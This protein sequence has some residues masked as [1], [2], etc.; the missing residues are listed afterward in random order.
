VRPGEHSI[1]VGDV[2][3]GNAIRAQ[4]LE[5]RDSI[6]VLLPGPTLVWVFLVRK[7]TKDLLETVQDTGTGV[8]FID[9]CRVHVPLSD[10]RRWPPNVA[11]VHARACSVAGCVKSCSALQLN[12]Q[13]GVLTSGVG[14]VI[15][16][17]GRGYKPKALGTENRPVG[18]ARPS[19]GD[20]G[21]A[22]RFY[23]EFRSVDDFLKW[24]QTL[25][26]LP[27]VL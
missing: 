19:Y 16:I 27:T 22:S 21:G 10:E 6:L 2:F 14:A 1:V 25:I 18:T 20:S 8:L 12:Q 24:C 11:I 7:P 15:K 13:T 3:A 26:E 9:G 5:L 4:G 17:S 23:V